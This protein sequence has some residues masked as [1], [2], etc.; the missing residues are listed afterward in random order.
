MM[1]ECF[2]E[3]NRFHLLKSLLY[4]KERRKMPVTIGLLVGI[5]NSNYLK[6]EQ[7][8]LRRIRSPLLSLPHERRRPT[9]ARRSDQRI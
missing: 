9:G 7:T 2:F 1:N 3:K 8:L 5:I 4:K 6:E